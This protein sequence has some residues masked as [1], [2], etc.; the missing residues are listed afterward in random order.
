M[1]LLVSSAPNATGSSSVVSA[2]IPTPC[3]KPQGWSSFESASDMGEKLWLGL[4]G[5]VA[6]A[7][8]V[9]MVMMRRRFAA[10]RLMRRRREDAR[11]ARR[12]A[13]SRELGLDLLSLSGWI[14]F[15]LD[16]IEKES[17]RLTTPQEESKTGVVEEHDSQD[18]EHDG[19]RSPRPVDDAAA[20]VYARLDERAANDSGQ[21][22]AVESTAAANV[23]RH[24]E[25]IPRRHQLTPLA[26]DERRASTG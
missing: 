19:I 23:R 17:D 15:R 5:T 12:Y 11:Y 22:V 2:P 20:T 8:A 3:M 24:N 25:A 26:I 9:L 6:C 13:R 21:R 1:E 18:D 4:V 10:D 14:S 7:V 16:L